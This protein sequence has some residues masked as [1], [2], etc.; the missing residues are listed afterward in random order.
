MVKAQP[1]KE[2]TKELPRLNG[3]LP[4]VGNLYY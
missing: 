1:K 4:W 2:K 3:I